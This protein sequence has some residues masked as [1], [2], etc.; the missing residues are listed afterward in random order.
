[1]S[2]TV[3]SVTSVPRRFDGALKAVLASLEQTG[4]Q[5][6]LSLPEAYNKW[7]AHPVPGYL[8]QM[9][10]VIVHRPAQDYGPA[11]KLL[12][13]LEYLAS[14]KSNDLPKYIVTFDDDCV[15][16]DPTRVIEV[17]EEAAEKNAQTAITF[18]G[19]KLDRPPFETHNGLFDNNVG[20]VD[21][22]IGWSGVL[23][24]V[25]P[26]LK[27]V[28][29][30]GRDIFAMLRD[31]PPGTVHNDDVYFGI[32][33]ARMGVPILSIRK[34]PLRTSGGERL[35][36][37]S[38]PTGGDSAVLEAVGKSPRLIEGEIFQ[39]AVQQ[40]WLPSR[41]AAADPVPAF[42]VMLRRNRYG[43]KLVNVFRR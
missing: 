25:A 43:R 15:S 16:N 27:G 42:E 2:Q 18:C 5:V 20:Y 6:I 19:L 12:G 30:Q 33:L 17:L 29:P 40:G 8:S 26:V 41:H 23:Y 4:R 36:M 31:M 9:P 28:D 21:G 38:L 3:I 10:H 7:G 13:G 32:A 35:V 11:T 24:P 14:N 34:R 22:V 1:M 37:R 39:H